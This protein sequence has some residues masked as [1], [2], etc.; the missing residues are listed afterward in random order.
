MKVT[1]KN[2]PTTKF[3]NLQ[4]G[5]VFKNSSGNI[6]IKINELDAETMSGMPSETLNAVDLETGET[7]FFYPEENVTPLKAE[8]IVE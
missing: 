5:E 8:L 7:T 6:F 4:E 1:R 2:D 3:Y